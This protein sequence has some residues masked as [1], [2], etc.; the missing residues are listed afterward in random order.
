VWAA[1]TVIQYLFN[2]AD[3]GGLQDTGGSEADREDQDEGYHWPVNPGHAI[4]LRLVSGVRED[5]E[6]QKEPDDEHTHT[7]L[8]VLMSLRK[9]PCSTTISASNKS[10]F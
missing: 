10:V 5:I 8:Q 9:N 4:Q 6:K 1:V 2:R 3:Q 7:T